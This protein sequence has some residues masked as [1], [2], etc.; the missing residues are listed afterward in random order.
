MK[1]TIKL[2]RFAAALILLVVTHIASAVA[3]LFVLLPGIAW[4]VSIIIQE[5]LEIERY[6]YGWVHYSTCCILVIYCML[7]N[8]NQRYIKI[9]NDWMYRWLNFITKSELK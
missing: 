7:F 2:V 4:I 3:T 9:Q 5:D 1:K 8:I 6:F